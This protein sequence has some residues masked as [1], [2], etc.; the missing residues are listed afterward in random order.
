MSVLG[1]GEKVEV[2]CEL[3]SVTGV[4]EYSGVQG[5]FLVGFEVWEIHRGKDVDTG[6]LLLAVRRFVCRGG[7]TE[8]LLTVFHCEV[9]HFLV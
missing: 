4:M 9:S 3:E 7:L 1:A 8:E 6:F 2:W 5:N